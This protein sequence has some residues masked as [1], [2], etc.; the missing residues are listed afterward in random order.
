MQLL[1]DLF[2]DYTLRNVALGTAILG[3]VSGVLG[4]FAILRRQGLF[5]D[6]LAHAT[7]PG[8]CLA[9]IVSGAR[10]PLVLLLGAA[11]TAGLGALFILAVTDGTR[12]KQDAALGLVLSVF[13]G[14]G[15]VLLTLIAGSGNASQSGIDR[16]IFGQAATIIR[17]D[18]VVMGV[19]GAVAL[20]VVA[21]LF[22]EFKL[23][24]FD[25]A[26]AAS[27]GYPV[28]RLGVLLTALIVVA[29]VIGI[30][31]VGVILMA[32]MLITPAAAARQWTDRLSAM[33]LVS[34]LFGALS[35]VAG[36]L[37]SASGAGLPTGPIVVLVATGIFVF[38]LVFGTRHGFL[39]SR[40]REAKNRRAALGGGESP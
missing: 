7:L 26:F 39:P 30:Q 2:T 15:T 23:I 34:G 10:D 37:V 12:I 31:T 25:P 32:A 22:K 18:V 8:V 14:V 36:A 20:F 17:D 24:S 19:L 3:V 16:F 33:V 27:L 35:G 6:A 13:F 29:I 11:V 9:F 4:C 21:L 40:L 1:L 38:S 5:G 28:G